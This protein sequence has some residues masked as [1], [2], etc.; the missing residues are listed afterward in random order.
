MKKYW[1]LCMP[2]IHVSESIKDKLDERKADTESYS[3]VLKRVIEQERDFY[4]DLIERKLHEL[5][6]SM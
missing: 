3:D 2:A 4:E 6:R 5:Q 1:V